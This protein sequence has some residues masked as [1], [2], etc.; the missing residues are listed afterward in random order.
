MLMNSMICKL[1]YFIFSYGPFWIYTTVV[2]CLS[3]VPNI[4]LYQ[5]S[6]NFQYNFE[7]VGVAFSFMYMIGFLYPVIMTFIMKIFGV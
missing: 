4:L 7:I 1:S 5:G 2:F 6:N 3:A